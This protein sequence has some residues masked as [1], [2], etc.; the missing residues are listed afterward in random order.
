[1]Q[2]KPYQEIVGNLTDI[3]SNEVYNKAIFSMIMEVD[4]PRDA[5]EVAEL[6]NYIG[7][8]IGIFNNNGEIRIKKMKKA[9]G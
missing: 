8:R 4:I 2:L 6:K 3:K 1:M 9:K 7:E 5:I